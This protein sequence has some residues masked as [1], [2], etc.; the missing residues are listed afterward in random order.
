MHT[1]PDGATRR[2]HLVD[3]VGDGAD[4]LKPRFTRYHNVRLDAR[5]LQ[6]LARRRRRRASSASAPATQL[7]H[8]PTS[9]GWLPTSPPTTRHAFL[10]G[11]C[12]RRPST[13]WRFSCC[14]VRPPPLM[15]AVLQHKPQLTR[16]RLAYPP[17]QCCRRFCAASPAC[18]D[19]AQ[20]ARRPLS[21]RRR[22]RVARVAAR[23][24]AA[25]APRARTV[26][27]VAAWVVAGECCR[28][29]EHLELHAPSNPGCVRARA[30]RVAAIP[31]AMGTASEAAEDSARRVCSIHL[32]LPFS[33]TGKKRPQ[34]T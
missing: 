27:R 6:L 17:G 28:R 4:G 33:S 24:A 11:Y 29:L 8:S 16:L 15:Q 18:A 30:N 21:S 12:A 13:S 26:R 7:R 2:L 22:R 9:S 32:F 14:P 34:A 23:P 10:R 20:R 5:V 25:G 31:A 3:E 1:V 19:G